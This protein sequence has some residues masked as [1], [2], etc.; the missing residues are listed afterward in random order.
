MQKYIWE[1]A[2]HADINDVQEKENGPLTEWLPPMYEKYVAVYPGMCNQG[3]S[4]IEEI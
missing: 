2:A 1:V 4:E 3:G